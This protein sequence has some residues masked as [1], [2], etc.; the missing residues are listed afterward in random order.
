MK[1]RTVGIFA[2]YDASEQ[3]LCA[4]YLARY[5]INCYRYTKWFVHEAPS[6]GSRFCGFSHQWDSEVVPW[7]GKR[8]E[9]IKSLQSCD[10]FFFFERNEEILDMLPGETVTAFVMNPH[11]RGSESLA[12][13]KRC[14]Y[15]LVAGNECCKQIMEKE[16]GL[17][18]IVWPF[19]SAMQCIPRTNPDFEKRPHLFFPAFG[20][21]PAERQFVI[22][23][24]E[25]VRLC[26]PNVQAAVGFY[27]ATVE[28]KPG[29]DSRT[30][31]WRLLRYLQ[32]SDWIIDLNTKPLF[33]LFPAFAGGYGLPWIGYD[34][35]PNT[36]ERNKAR[37]HLIQAT[38]PQTPE[39][40]HVVPE[41]ETT[42]KQIVTRLGTPLQGDLERHAG[43]GAW[44][45]RR[46][47]FLHVTNLILGC[48]TKHAS[49]DSEK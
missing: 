37:R 26:L 25:I 24:A 9:A 41:L 35:A 12:F 45:N 39:N 14:R 8:K 6:P 34:L 18:P 13:A 32:T 4:E 2:R 38:L 47:E 23:V 28:P 49:V 42:A 17:H 16:Y 11:D 19:D 1:K 48:K 27:D 3:T 22:D 44:D 30:H 31:D 15:S 10:T 5:V 29:V 33:G 46:A 40:P 7:H 20:F 36:D 43:A 21:S